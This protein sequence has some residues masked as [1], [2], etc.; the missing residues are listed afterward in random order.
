LVQQKIASICA[1][2]YGAQMLLEYNPPKTRTAVE[3]GPKDKNHWK[4]PSAVTRD[5]RS[6]YRCVCT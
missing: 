4:R 1:H 5:H 2:R 3:G 6:L